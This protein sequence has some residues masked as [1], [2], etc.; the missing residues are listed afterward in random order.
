MEYAVEQVLIFY[1]AKKQ[2]DEMLR[3]ARLVVKGLK[4]CLLPLRISFLPIKPDRIDSL[5][6][7]DS[8]IP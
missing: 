2:Y 6:S 3:I 7:I 4:K 1:L 8:L 5:H